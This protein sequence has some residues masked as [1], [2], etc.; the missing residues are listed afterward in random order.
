MWSAAVVEVQIAA[1]GG[2]GLA[3]VVVGLQINLLVF[4]A[5]PQPLD[6]HIVPPRSFA[7]HADGNARSST[8]QF[9][10]AGAGSASYIVTQYFFERLAKI[11]TTHMAVATPAR[12]ERSSAAMS[13]LGVD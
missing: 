5:A 4:D 13:A 3:D 8:A 10:T 9:G 2:T 1:D 7:V 12:E 11:P 6:E